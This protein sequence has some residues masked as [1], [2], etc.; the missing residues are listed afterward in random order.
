VVFV[1][2]FRGKFEPAELLRILAEHKVTTF[3]A[4]PTVYR[5][6]VRQDLKQYDLSALRH[7]TTAG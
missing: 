3:C 4:P 1:W 7:C 2:D 6:L 5:F